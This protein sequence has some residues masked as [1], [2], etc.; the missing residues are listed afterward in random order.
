MEKYAKV[1][2]D[3]L[4]CDM[5]RIAEFYSFAKDQDNRSAMALFQSQLNEISAA[6]KERNENASY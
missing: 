1:S 4:Y 3:Q 2:I 5:T 6:I